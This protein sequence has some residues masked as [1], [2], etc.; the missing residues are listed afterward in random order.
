[1]L[2]THHSCGFVQVCLCHEPDEDDDSGALAITAAFPYADHGYSVEYNSFPENPTSAWYDIS[3]GSIVLAALEGRTVLECMHACD[4]APSCAGV[5]ITTNPAVPGVIKCY[6]LTALRTGPSTSAQPTVSL[7]KQGSESTQ[8]PGNI[9]TLAGD[10]TPEWKEGGLNQATA[11]GLAQAECVSTMGERFLLLTLTGH[12]RIVRL[13]LVTGSM[14]HIAGTGEAGSGGVGGA[15][16]GAQLDR[17][18]CAVADRAGNVFISD[19]GNHRVVVV[20]AETSVLTVAVGAGYAGHRGMGAA[21]RA[22]LIHTPWGLAFDGEGKSL[23]IAD[24]GNHVIYQYDLTAKTID[25]VAGTPGQ[26]GFGHVDADALETYA[27][28]TDGVSPTALE[29]MA[30]RATLFD[31]PTS[32]AFGGGVLYV[33]DTNN[34]RI[35]A[36]STTDGTAAPIAGAG[37]WTGTNDVTKRLPALQTYLYNPR[38][39]AVSSDGS[40]LLVADTRNHAVRLFD[41]SDDASMG[42]LVIGTNVRGYNGDDNEPLSTRLFFPVSAVFTN[43]DAAVT[44]VDQRNK[45]VR[46][47][48]GG[49]RWSV[50]C[51]VSCG[52]RAYVCECVS[53]CVCVISRHLTH[54]GDACLLR[55]TLP[56]LHQAGDCQLRRF[57][58]L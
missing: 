52:A 32:L 21:A 35:R 8:L 22:A 27:A 18:R 33:A 34:H 55:C 56:R 58:S 15:A 4:A 12:H 13:D 53:V 5:H 46:R 9:E 47:V 24:A 36:V 11:T 1:M 39:V 40:R 7:R 19:S 42:S 30:R 51:G 20:D 49:E 31:M 54:S 38:G 3:D 28:V 44:F 41:L 17:P 50:C 2:L 25:L 6:Q 57:F 23:F 10:G 37:P 43:G 45:R 29:E 14:K 16:A 26:S 48:W